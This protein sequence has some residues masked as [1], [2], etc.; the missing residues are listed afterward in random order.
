VE[1]VECFH[2]GVGVSV[3]F[4]ELEEL[5]ILIFATNGERDISKDNIRIKSSC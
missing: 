4:G 2:T 5:K 3:V 1:I